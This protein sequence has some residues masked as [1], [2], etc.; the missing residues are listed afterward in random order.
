MGCAATKSSNPV[1]ATSGMNNNNNA[2]VTPDA[3]QGSD[4][5]DTAQAQKSP[6]RNLDKNAWIVMGKY[7]MK[8]SKQDI[9]GEGTSSICR[10]GINLK[11]REE[12]AIKVYKATR[13]GKKSEDVKLQKFKRQIEVLQK[14]QEPFEAP[15]DKRLWHPSIA[16]SKPAKLFM[17]L[18]DY[19]QDANGIPQKDATDGMLYVVTE[20]AQYSLKDYLALRREQGKSLSK[21][22]IRNISKAIILVVAGLH[23]KGLVHL[24]LKPEN[25]MMFDGRLKLIDVDGCVKAGSCVSIQD[26]SISFSPCYCA[27]EW[28]RFLVEEA[29]STITVKPDLDVWSIGMTLCEL[30]TLDAILKPMYADF[31]RNGHSHREAGFLFMDWLGNVKKAPLP[32]SILRYD[33]DFYVLLSESLLVCK[34]EAGRRRLTLAECLEDAYFKTDTEAAAAPENEAANQH[35][36]P[37]N[38]TVERKVR[39]RLEDTSSKAPLYKGTLW[40]LNSGGNASN[41][42]HWLKRDMWV[43]CNGS[44]CY[45]SIKENKRLVLVDSAK[46]SGARI[47]PF[48]RGEAAREHCFQVFVESLDEKEQDVHLVFSAES[49]AEYDE[50]ME[51]VVSAANLDAAM[52][53]M[54]LGGEMADQ[55]QT[56]RL[57]VKNRRMK[58]VENE[59]DQFAPIFQATLWKVKAEGDRMKEADW[60]EREMWISKN[61]SLVYWSK[62]EERELVYYTADDIHDATFTLIPNEQSFK[63]WAFQVHLIGKG[64]V[65]FAPG[66]FAAQSEAMRDS[67]LAEFKKL[68]PIS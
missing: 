30:V 52:Q 35:G 18:L 31:L 1:T 7:E 11:T 29:E 4:A 65:E 40:K 28:A 20:L 64:G 42:T 17:Q 3:K 56:F 9:M 49:K 19:S 62:K 2:Y 34:D 44:L 36:L 43:S 38:E 57:G 53:T 37:A 10:K 50:W 16:T 14:L 68:Q 5:D 55:I 48:P 61:G 60:F 46:L 63:P 45:F 59:K 32:K 33:K 25:L 21:E 8:M 6:V 24:D 41:S 58:V 15:E 12:V 66:E 51:K 39:V 67:W 27:P 54:R 13:D 26:S 23:A 47:T 22:A